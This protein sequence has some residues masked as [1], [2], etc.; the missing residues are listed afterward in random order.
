VIRL[1]LST[2]SERT[3]ATLERLLGEALHDMV[4]KKRPTA[5]VMVDAF[6]S[7]FRV[8]VTLL[9]RNRRKPAPRKEP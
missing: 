2:T 4:A 8:T 6:S 9:D 5:T 7:E 1:D 3:A